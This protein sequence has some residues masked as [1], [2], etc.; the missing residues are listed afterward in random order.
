VR[1]LIDTIPQEQ[2]RLLPADSTLG[3][4]I[5]HTAEAYEEANLVDSWLEWWTR[6]AALELLKGVSQK[7]ITPLAACQ[8]LNELLAGSLNDIEHA[9]AEIV[10]VDKKVQIVFNNWNRDDRSPRS[11]DGCVSDL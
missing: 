1:V 7:E 11:L 2:R 4:L 8:K 5:N 3:L 9:L 6:P 10:D